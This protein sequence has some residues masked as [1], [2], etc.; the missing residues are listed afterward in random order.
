[1]NNLKLIMVS[2]MVSLFAFGCASECESDSDC[3]KGEVCAVDSTD[4][5]NAD[6]NSDDAKGGTC[7]EKKD[8]AKK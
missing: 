1:M 2:A 4:E 7:E 6:E 8:E 3:E 5:A